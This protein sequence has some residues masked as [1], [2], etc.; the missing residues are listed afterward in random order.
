MRVFREIFDNKT[1]RAA[2]IIFLLILAVVVFNVYSKLPEDYPL[3]GVLLFSAVPLLFI[4]GGLVFVFA[5][6]VRSVT[7]SKLVFLMSAGALGIM[8]LV[9]GG[10]QLVDFTDSVAFCG[11]LCHTVMYPEY[12]VY[13][14]SPHSRVHC[15]S[16]H[17]GPGAGYLVK[18]KLAG[19]PLIFSTITRSYDRP[20]ATPVHSLRPARDTCEECHRPERY[21]GE[22]VLQHTTYAEDEQNTSSTDT[23]IFNV[24]G[25]QGGTAQGIHWH[26]ASTVYYLP[27][28]Q[29]RQDI[30]YV[31]VV[32]SNGEEVDYISPSQEDQVTDERIKKDERLMDCVDCHNRAT[33]QF[34]SPEILLDNAF[35]QGE[36]DASLPY[37]KRE[38][39]QALDP[40]NSSLDE[41]YAK[42]EAIADFYR[43]NYPQVYQQ[44]S[45][46]IASDIDAIKGIA[47]LTT[48]P[49]MRVTWDTYLN[50][51]G[52]QNAP[53]CF[54]CH[55]NLVAQA[56]PTKGEILS[57]DCS[58]CHF[59][60]PGP[61][62][63]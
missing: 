14:A 8:L 11:R 54:R 7:R 19:V 32:T 39:S 2:G 53:G 41:A 10:Y 17:V 27:L 1:T 15:V 22:F 18:S 36:L 5:I 31:R 42:V 21:T 59:I 56:G 63:K 51:I 38:A 44:K 62:P 26:I 46:E 57:A 28:D 34:N 61:I 48:F 29:A 49:Y 6:L 25:G 37:L 9:V 47:Q 23:R 4:L 30:A 24:G 40:A 43:T 55:G 13:Q 16:C 33:H 58:L 60:L 12:T 20:I 52:H 3:F 35:A 50:N 45:A